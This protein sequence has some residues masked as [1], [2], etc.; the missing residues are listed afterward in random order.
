MYYV[1]SNTK[2]GLYGLFLHLTVLKQRTSG[3][4][5]LS[6]EQQQH[7][8]HNVFLFRQQSN[9]YCT[10]ACGHKFGLIVLYRKA[11]QGKSV[12]LIEKIPHIVFSFSFKQHLNQWGR[13]RI[14]CPQFHR[15]TV[16]CV[17]NRQFNRLDCTTYGILYHFAIKMCFCAVVTLHGT[18]C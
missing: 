17:E 15:V 13:F 4:V 11:W 14:I 12:F 3:G 6:S 9:Q 8:D 1:F 10:S 7:V 18:Q 16:G 5:W 2:S